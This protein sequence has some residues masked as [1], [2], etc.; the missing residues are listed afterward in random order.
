MKNKNN[1]CGFRH[2]GLDDRIQIEI[3]YSQGK[4][5]AEIAKILGKGRNK[6]T[7]AREINGHPRKGRG[8]YQ[9]YQAN[10]RVLAKDKNRGKRQ[11][12]KNELIRNYC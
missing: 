3:Q 5:F 10:A 11:R 8:R 1:R 4:S 12:L 9:A 6:S 7:I 2:L